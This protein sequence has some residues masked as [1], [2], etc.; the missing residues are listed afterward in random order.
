MKERNETN[1][2][3]VHIILKPKNTELL[4]IELKQKNENVS[5]RKEYVTNWE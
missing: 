1:Q 3:L 5:N 2:K 4:R